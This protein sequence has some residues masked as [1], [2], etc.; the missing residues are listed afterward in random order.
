[1]STEFLSATL[2][3]QFMQHALLACLLASLGCGIT[4]TY[5][6]VK[7]ISF[8]AGGIA[9]T[10]LAGIQV[11]RNRHDLAESEA[12]REL[13]RFCNAMIGI[14]EEIAAIEAGE[15][16]AED[17]LLRNAPHT[18]HMLLAG[19]WTKPYSRQQAFF[20]MHALREE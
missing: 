7:R 1:M 17:N 16:D 13:D 4:G 3:Y 11:L 15:A 2:N 14:R 9:H 20:P 5:V 10:V 12:K 19:E 18:H 6:V 8:M